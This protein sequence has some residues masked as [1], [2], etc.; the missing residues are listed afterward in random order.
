M[1]PKKLVLANGCT[2]VGMG[3]GE[4]KVAELV[5]NTSMV[6]YQEIISDP[7]YTG[8]IVVMTYPL[9]GNYGTNDED[10]ESKNLHVEGFIVKD[11]NME[12]SNFRYTNTLVDLLDEYKIPLLTG[13]D[14]RAITRIIRDEGSMLGIIT[15]CETPMEV[16]LEKINSYVAPHNQVAMVTTKR[17]VLTKAKKTKYQVVCIDFGIKSNIVNNLNQ[18]NCN[19][20][21]L[22]ANTKFETVME[23]KPDG[24]FLS[25]GPGDPIDN[26]EAIELVQKLKGI[27]PI[28]G[29][30]L[31]HQ[32]M[33]LASGAKTKKMKFGHR[34]SNHPVKNM[35]TGKIEIT[36]QNHSYMVD[37]DSIKDTDLEITHINLLD[38]S[39]EGVKCESKMFQSIQYHPESAAG[40]EDSCYLFDQFILTMKKFKEGK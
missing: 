12:P 27:V 29:I 37:S 21:L 38:N 34:G 9:I 1:K 5:F 2:F 10:F 28:F 4:D 36:S 7:S 6:G 3:F 16:A 20:V 31:G 40:P 13:V 33:S 30:C 39:I 22:P 32:I 18:R 35:Q 25:N 14:T 15:D 26:V 8:Q 19:V 23:Y 17:P 24:V 11:C